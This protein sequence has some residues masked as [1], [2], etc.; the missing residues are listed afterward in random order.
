M[1]LGTGSASPEC[2]KLILQGANSLLMFRVEA[3]VNLVSGV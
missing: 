1:R 3:L 2:I